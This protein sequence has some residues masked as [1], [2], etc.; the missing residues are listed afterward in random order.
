MPPGTPRKPDLEMPP[1]PAQ[2]VHQS[3]S[4]AE[5][6]AQ[7]REAEQQEQQQEKQQAQQAQQQ[8][9]QVQQPGQGQPTSTPTPVAGPRQPPPGQAEPSDKGLTKDAASRPSGREAGA[10]P[11]GKDLAGRSGGK[12]AAVPA[13]GAGKDVSGAAVRE[14]KAPAKGPSRLQQEP[15]QEVGQES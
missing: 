7:G 14:H 8:A 11:S 6:A 2:P 10:K 5:L 12:D 13:K 1:P 4:A 15:R 9:Q 3:A